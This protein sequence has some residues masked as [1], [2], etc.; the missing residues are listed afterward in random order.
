ML[1]WF[2]LLLFCFGFGHCPARPWMPCL[3]AGWAWTAPGTAAWDSLPSA[4]PVPS[5]SAGSRRASSIA[6]SRLEEAMSEL[7]ITTSVLKQGPMQLWTT[8]E[9]IWLQAG[10]CPLI[11]LGSGRS[12]TCVAE[13]ARWPH[14]S[15]T[16]RMKEVG[17]SGEAYTGLHPCVL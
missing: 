8:L 14:P 5:C 2:L 13:A 9:Q 7:T 15:L 4:H 6:A 10:E 12:L 1:C 11:Q 16:S 17:M 3:D